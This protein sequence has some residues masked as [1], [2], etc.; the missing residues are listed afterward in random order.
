MKF[1]WETIFSKVISDEHFAFTERVKV[2]G[3]WIVLN[4]IYAKGVGHESSVFV[5]DPE[6][7]WEITK[8]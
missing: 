8:D 3:G 4:K 7:K 5:P 6:H 2:I 1:E